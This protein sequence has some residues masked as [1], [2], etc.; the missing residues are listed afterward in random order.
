MHERA[1]VGIETFKPAQIISLPQ[2]K[3]ICGEQSSQVR[4]LKLFRNRHQVLLAFL[5]VIV[6]LLL[7]FLFIFRPLLAG[8]TFAVANNSVSGTYYW[9]TS[10]SNNPLP[11]IG[12]ISYINETHAFS[13]QIISSQL[14]FILLGE[15]ANQGNLILNTDGSYIF[16]GNVSGVMKANLT[17]S[18]I[19][20]SVND[21]GPG[22]GSIIGVEFVNSSSNNNGLFYP[23][24]GFN[25][26]NPPDIFTDSF[27]F[28]AGWNIQKPDSVQRNA[29]GGAFSFRALF[30]LSYILTSRVTLPNY[31]AFD[32]MLLGLN[33]NVSCS[34]NLHL[35]AY[36]PLTASTTR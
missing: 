26:S 22:M 10:S 9:N 30:I 14:S 36:Q 19:R 34:I 4:I 5:V 7:I 2:T 3:R 8:P 28:S 18:A 23:V 13:S 29:N 25:M 27:P 11:S 32:V 24:N 6:S 16:T 1:S 12:V 20:I 33:E 21:S 35:D 17:P 15:G 31:F